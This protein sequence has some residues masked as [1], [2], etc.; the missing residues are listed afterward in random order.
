V[1]WCQHNALGVG[2]LD[3]Y[4]D[5][6]ER[7]YFIT[8]ESVEL[9]IAEEMAKAASKARWRNPPEAFGHQLKVRNQRPP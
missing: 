2:K 3:A 5:P 6:N 4:F 7:K 8:P 1:N 9:A